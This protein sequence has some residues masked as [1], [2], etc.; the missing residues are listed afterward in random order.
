MGSTMFDRSEVLLVGTTLRANPVI[1]QGIP[2]SA[3]RDPLIRISVSF[4]INV[5]ATTTT[6]LAHDSP[7]KILG[8][9]QA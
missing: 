2:L 9:I 4:V 1:G 3:R 8:L 7:P 5:I 6:P